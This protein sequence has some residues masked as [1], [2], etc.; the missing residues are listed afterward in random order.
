V[1][2][3]GA[4]GE[5]APTRL[6]GLRPGFGQDNGR[7]DPDILCLRSVPGRTSVTCSVIPGGRRCPSPCSRMGSSVAARDR[8][9]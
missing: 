3:S 2:D 1:S 9:S 8:L 4:Q 7:P 6:Y 5:R